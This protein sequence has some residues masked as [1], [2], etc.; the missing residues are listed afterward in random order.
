MKSHTSIYYHAGAYGTFIEWCLNYFSNKNF[1]DKLPFTSTGSAHKFNGNLILSETMYNGMKLNPCK[2][3]RTHPGCT[4]EQNYNLLNTPT[5]PIDCYRTELN[6]LQEISKNVIV[7][8]FNHDN[9]LWGTNNVIKSFSKI[10]PTLENYF[11]H[12]QYFRYTQGSCSSL[13]ERIVLDLEMANS[14]HYKQ[15]NRNSWQDMQNWELREFL[16]LYVEGQ[17]LDLYYSLETI[18]KE[19]PHVVFIEIGCLRDDFVN[20]ITELFQKIN[21]SL[22]KHNLDEIFSAWSDTQT[23]AHRDTEVNNIVEAI[24]NKK[25]LEWGEI[26]IIDEAVIQK[27][28][29]DN[30]LHIKCFGLNIFPRSVKEFLNVIE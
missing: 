4:N 28:L 12:N 16:S 21:L 30:N 6:Y 7:L 23:F 8:Y 22:E 10:T 20:T 25:D 11:K 14:S 1:N 17:W 13:R 15:W 26:S 24:F 2:F 29:R 27:K 19:F 18:Q 5:S 3:F 9:I